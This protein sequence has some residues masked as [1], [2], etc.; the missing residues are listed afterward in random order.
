[1]S[2]AIDSANPIVAA[3]NKDVFFAPRP[4]AGRADTGAAERL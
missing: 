4:L 2:P 3:P 1:M